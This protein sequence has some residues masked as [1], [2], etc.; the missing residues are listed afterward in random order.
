MANTLFPHEGD[1]QTYS[2][3][4]HSILDEMSYKGNRVASTRKSELNHLEVLFRELAARIE[5][6]GLQTLTL[7]SPDKTESNTGNDIASE[8][9]DAMASAEQE[10]LALSVSGDQ[11]VLP[12][13]PRD[14]EFLDN[15]GI[16]S[17]DFLS[18][19]NQMGNPDS[20]CVLDPLEGPG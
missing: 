11:P 7:S 16:S 1:G 2:K 9:Q 18:L 6:R 3:E 15:I 20:Y 4:A 14:L 10:A 8:Q 12:Q 17:Y 13:T 19:V 5:R